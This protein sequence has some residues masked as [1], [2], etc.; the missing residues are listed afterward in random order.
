MSETPADKLRKLL[1]GPRTFSFIFVSFV[2]KKVRAP[3]LLY[4]RAS[5]GTLHPLFFDLVRS[6]GC[7]I[8]V[9]LRVCSSSLS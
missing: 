5:G 2:V 7:S 3:P 4:R 9:V 1:D 8:V 6:P